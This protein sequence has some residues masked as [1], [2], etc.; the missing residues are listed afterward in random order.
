MSKKKHIQVDEPRV[1]YKFACAREDRYTWT[2]R[3]A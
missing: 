1:V 3:K 2:A